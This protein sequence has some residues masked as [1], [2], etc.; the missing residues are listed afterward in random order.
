MPSAASRKRLQ[1]V[2]D[3][4]EE[5]TS[6]AAGLPPR[7][8]AAAAAT[9]QPHLPAVRR[10]SAANS[11]RAA[12]PSS[13]SRSRQRSARRSSCGIET[14]RGRVGIQCRPNRVEIEST[15]QFGDEL[16]LAHQGAAPGDPTGELDS[17]A[18]LFRQLETVNQPHGR[19]DQPV[20]Q[21]LDGQG[22]SLQFTLGRRRDA[23]GQ[24]TAAHGSM[25]AGTIR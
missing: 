20:G 14:G 23:T 3:A 21:L 8:S 6:R 25:L 22:L 13:T 1:N 24:L 18:E 9:S 2:L 4:P 7:R 12:S 19:G 17:V 5:L 10:D 15:H 11:A 16:P